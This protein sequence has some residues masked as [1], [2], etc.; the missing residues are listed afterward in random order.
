M[1]EGATVYDKQIRTNGTGKFTFKINT[2]VQADYDIT[3]VFTKKN[4]ITRR[5]N[6]TAKRELT[7]EDV[8]NQ[9]RSNAVKPA[10]TTL[11]KK[12]D[13]YVGRTMVYTVYIT[14]IQQVGDEWVIFA[15]M[16]Q[17]KKGYSNMLVITA[18]EQPAFEVGT[19]QKMYGTCIGTYQ[20]QSE[21]DLTSYPSFDLLF[22]D[23]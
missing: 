13:G 18:E 19:Q 5:L 2:S 22:W 16:K 3:L 11:V 20:V 6:S 8:R 23:S 7:E 15:A 21:E 12:L 10:Y 17:T 14:D 9:I 4:Y 1:R